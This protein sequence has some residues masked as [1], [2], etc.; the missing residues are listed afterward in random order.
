MK[1]RKKPITVDAWKIE[2][3]LRLSRMGAATLPEEVRL[4]YGEGL[5]EFEEDE[6]I[7]IATLEGVMTG[8]PMWWLIRGVKG[9][10]YPCD[11]EAFEKSYDIVEA[12][13]PS[14]RFNVPAVDPYANSPEV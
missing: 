7:T 14:L 13:E 4:A 12:E 5:I 3:L 8:W 1:V 9:E 11:Q 2:D 6:R 10:W